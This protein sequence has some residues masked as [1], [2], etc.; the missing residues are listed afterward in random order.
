MLFLPLSVP[1]LRAQPPLLRQMM[2]QAS[3][4]LSLI[5]VQKK[6]LG[7]SALKDAFTGTMQCLPDALR[8][9]P[10]GSDTY[11]WSPLQKVGNKCTCQV[12]LQENILRELEKQGATQNS[13]ALTTRGDYLLLWI[14][15]PS[16][17]YK[18]A[19]SASSTR[20]HNYD[21]SLRSHAA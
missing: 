20:L 15:R 10:K 18:N 5:I 1:H 19:E 6:S 4:C 8:L 7:H 9:S 21:A 17:G 12:A 13:R 16:T 2:K 11:I 14:S 3:K